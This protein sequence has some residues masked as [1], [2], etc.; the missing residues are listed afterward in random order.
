[1]YNGNFIKILIIFL[2]FDVV[3]QYWVYIVFILL[4][5][6]KTQIAKKNILNY[7]TISLRS[8]NHFFCKYLTPLSPARS[9]RIP[10]PI[11]SPPPGGSS[12]ED[13]LWFSEES[14]VSSWLTFSSLDLSTCFWETCLWRSWRSNLVAFML[15]PMLFIT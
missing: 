3:L 11:P 6:H 4:F 14:S 9:P 12:S 8:I 13:E 1:M 5:H 2:W 15:F 10:P 7:R